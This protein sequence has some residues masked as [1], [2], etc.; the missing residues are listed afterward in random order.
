MTNDNALGDIPVVGAALPT[1]ALPTYRDWLLEKQR[2]LELQ[3]MHSATVLNGDWQSEVSEAKKHLDGY[4]GR[5]GIHGPFWGFS[6]QSPDP[7]VQAI[8]TKRM[9]QGLDVCEALNA[10]QMVIHSPVTTWD[11]NN[12]GNQQGALQRVIETVHSCLKDVVKRAENQ[13][14]ELVME[15]IEDIDPND[16]LLIV[17]SFDSDAIQLSLDTGHAHYA[18]VSN[19]APPVDYFVSAAGNALRHVHLQDA[20]GYADRH[21]AL[22]EGTVN[23]FA[24]FRAIGRLESKPRLVFELRDPSGIPSSI[25]HLESAGLAQ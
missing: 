11:Y 23:W 14:V 25:A 9:M 8:V 24:V 15:N 12:F 21:W 5:L 4:S 1:S 10:S 13:G 2:D 3:S 16:R 17:S 19:G 20:D 6:I 7:D 22:G 18:H